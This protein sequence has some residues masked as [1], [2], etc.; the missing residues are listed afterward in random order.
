MRTS[1]KNEPMKK[2]LF[3]L[4]AF[5][6]SCTSATLITGS[7]KNPG[8]PSQQNKSIVVATLTGH[9]VARSTTENDLVDLLNA[10]KITAYKSIDLFPPKAR[11]SDSDKVAIMQK[12]KEKNIDA[13]LTVALLKKETET[14]YVPGATV[15]SP[16]HVGYYRS[17]WGYYS[18]SYDSY[19]EP[20]YYTNDTVYYIETNMYDVKSEELIWSAQ[21]KTYKGPDLA[22][23]SKD[24]AKTIVKKLK[25]D[26]IISGK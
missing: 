15:Y 12:V 23:F 11:R 6:G 4:L 20:G 25:A 14:R 24:F 7:W 19:Y 9:T 22:T 26:K 16:L 18:Y 8:Y 1:T 5:L 21:S 17:F 10:E 2:A 3:I 13:I